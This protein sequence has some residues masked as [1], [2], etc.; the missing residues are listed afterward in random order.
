MIGDAAG[1]WLNES[2]GV[3]DRV[4]G[5]DRGDGRDYLG[6]YA[7]GQ[8]NK[9]WVDKEK[10]GLDTYAKENDANVIRTKVKVDY[11]GSPQ[12]G[13][14]YD[15]LEKNGDGPNTYTAIEVKSGSAFDE[16]S[17]PGNT[18]GQF[19]NTVN[20]GTPARGVLD[21]EEILITKVET[22]IVP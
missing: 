14:Y 7:R 4:R 21:G 10:I 2:H 1:R 8:D 9:P 5:V 6:H 19:D 3:G 16:Y 11:D 15:G 18:Q 20:G 22:V 12:N 17:M 13:R